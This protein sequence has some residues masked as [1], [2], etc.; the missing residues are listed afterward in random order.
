[1][2]IKNKTSKF[3]F[4]PRD[5]VLLSAFR[6]EAGS[7]RKVFSL[8]FRPDILSRKENVLSR[9]TISKSFGNF[10]L[11]FPSRFE[12]LRRLQRIDCKSVR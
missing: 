3:H 7:K 1:M 11:K 9:I 4:N 5:S 2:Q 10:L 8:R 12:K 6:L